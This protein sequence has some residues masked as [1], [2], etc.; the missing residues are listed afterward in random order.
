VNG[1]PVEF[2]GVVGDVRSA[3]PAAEPEP[4]VYLCEYQNW[5]S[6]M[7]MVLRTEGDPLAVV[8]QVRSTLAAIDPDQPLTRL[9]TLDQVI[10]DSVARPRSV[11]GLLGLFAL[12]AG[13]LAAVGLYGVLAFSVAQRTRELGIR[14]ALGADRGRIVL[15]VV[16]QG[17]LFVLAGLAAG[18][19]LAV[20]AGRA[21]ESLLYGVGTVDPVALAGAA[22]L[23]VLT[24]LVAS[25][26][27]ALRAARVHPARA[28]RQE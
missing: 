24:G 26:V 13:V 10:D 1:T 5:R 11:A 15:L 18:V 21:L 16:R 6:V 7:S 12:L 25:T 20:L 27:P 2:I 19:A 17:M 8:P 3:G 14:Q 23:L 22:A 28:L 4:M 9:A